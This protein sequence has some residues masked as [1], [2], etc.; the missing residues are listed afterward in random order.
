MFVSIITWLML[1]FLALII[2]AY[3]NLLGEYALKIAPAG[4]NFSQKW[5]HLGPI[6]L[7][8]SLVSLLFAPIIFGSKFLLDVAESL[9]A[10]FKNLKTLGKEVFPK[11]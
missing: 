2:L 10:F 4:Y 7:I 11:K 3:W 9:Y 1:G 5:S 6:M 8:I